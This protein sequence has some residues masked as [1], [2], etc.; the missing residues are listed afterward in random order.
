VSEQRRFDG[1]FDHL[2]HRR[3]GVREDSESAK[4]AA[5]VARVLS[6]ELGL[7]LIFVR[8]VEPE[9]PNA[10]MSALAERLQRLRAGATDV[11]GGATWLVDAGHPADGLVAAATKADA[12]LIVIG[13]TGPRSS[14]LGS[15]SADVSRRAPCPVVVV[16]PGA[17]AHMNGQA[18]ER[19][20]STCPA[21]R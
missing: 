15:I 7:G 16:P 19:G 17:D 13:S 18:I 9:T 1:W 10:G 6:S 3:L 5:R 21:T 14:R 11:D 8:V 20:G 4:G 2:W 12:S